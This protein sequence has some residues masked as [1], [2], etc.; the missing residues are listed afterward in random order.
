MILDHDICCQAATVSRVPFIQGQISSNK[1]HSGALP[2]HSQAVNWQF[3]TVLFIRRNVVYHVFQNIR[4]VK[5]ITFKRQ[6]KIAAKD[7]LIFHFYLLKKIGPSR[8]FT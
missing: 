1:H 2:I 8:G 6:T 4:V 5:I 7:I 3:P